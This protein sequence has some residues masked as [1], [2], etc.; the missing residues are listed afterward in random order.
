[1]R[2]EIFLELGAGSAGA[3]VVIAAGVV[4]W[5]AAGPGSPSRVSPPPAQIAALPA[6]AVAAKSEPMVPAA[7]S[8]DIVKIAPDGSAVIAGRA[9]PGA[10]V[11]VLDDGKPLGEVDA[12]R[13]G[14]WVLTPDAPLA[15]GSRQ[16]SLEAIDPQT[17]AKASS[18]DTVA[19]A[20]AP[21]ARPEQSLAVLLPGDADKPVQALQLPGGAPQS[22]ALSLDSA[23]FGGEDRV[24][25]SGHAPAGAKVNIYAGDKPLGAVTAD[26]AGS[27]SLAAPRPRLAG[28]YDLR[29]EQL[30][31]D[32]N[33]ASRVARAFEAP[34]ALTVPESARYT[35]KSGNNLWWIAR[36]TYGE[37]TRYTLIYGANRGH[38]HD[39]NLIYPGQVFSLPRS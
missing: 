34:P 17:G 16:L 10:H 28:N 13:R 6:P 19:L 21:P 5:C 4:F 35:V 38:I 39:P 15:P 14:E 30:G 20:V 24:V 11:R 37:G 2:R 12:D 32:G 1:M 3:A 33:V 9:E 23:D 36:R 18:H 26:K 22:G 31:T 27:W 29:A 7:P 8:F 25:L